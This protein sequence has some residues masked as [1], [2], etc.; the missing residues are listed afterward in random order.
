MAATVTLSTTTLQAAISASDA[1]VSVGST[2]GIV[3][4]VFLYIDRE[5][6]GVVRLGLGAS[7]VVQRGVG[8]TAASAHASAS[9]V[10]I[11]RGDQFYDH[12]PLGL[13]PDVVAVSPWINV[14]TGVQWVAYGDESGIG[15]KARSWQPTVITPSIGDLGIRQTTSTP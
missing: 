4:G 5:L 2:S 7:V 8:G 10:T 9:T 3:P 11:G 15:L 12:N 1:L 13:P 6:M 14:L